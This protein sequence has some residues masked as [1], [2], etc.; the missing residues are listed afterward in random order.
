MKMIKITDKTDCCGCGACAQICPKCCISMRADSEGFLY[1]YVDTEN[2]IECGLCRQVCPVLRQSERKKTPEIYAAYA[3]NEEIREDSS[4]GGIF[5]LLANFVLEAHGVVFGAAFDDD[6]SV[7]HIKVESTADMHKLRGSKYLQSCIDNTYAEARS[8]LE[9]GRMVLFSGVG[10][11]IAGLKAYLKKDYT[12]LYTVDVLCHGVPSP[13]LWQHYL[14][15]QKNNYGAE[16]V[17][18][19]FRKKNTGWKTYSE[20]QIFQSGE[21]YSRMHSEDSFIQCFLRDVCLRPSCYSCKFREGQSGADLTLGDAWGIQNW[22]PELDDDRG[23]SIVL[24]N[25]EKGRQMWLQ[26]AGQ[27]CSRQG[28]PEII[29]Q[30]NSVYRKSMAEH[31]GRARFFASLTRGAPMEELVKLSR[32]PLHRRALSF[33]KRVLKSLLKKIGIL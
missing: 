31:P 25:S 24:V 30:Y 26:I 7:H 1:P 15:E 28:N 2:C 6:F 33:G 21:K 20:E 3:L 17:Q 12:N 8:F 23:T 11:Q 18:I 13:K 16:I 5:S 27:T 32:K 19:S 4:S 29:L 22:M 14:R 9:A 10:C